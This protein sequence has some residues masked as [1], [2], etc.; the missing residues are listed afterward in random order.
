MLGSDVRRVGR[1]ALCFGV[2]NREGERTRISG[3][4]ILRAES[5][6]AVGDDMRRLADSSHQP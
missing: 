3:E 5:G 1:P 2:P 4:Q 6:L